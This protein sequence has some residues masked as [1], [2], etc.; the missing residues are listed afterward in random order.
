M[1]VTSY[2]QTVSRKLKL[3]RGWLHFLAQIAFW[4]GFYVVYQLARG[5]ADRDV[6]AAFWNGIHVIR[7]E[8]WSGTLFEP[9]LQ[10]MVDSSSLLITATTLVAVTLLSVRERIRDYGVLKAIGLTPLQITSTVVS[11]HAALARTRSRRYTAS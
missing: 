10:R 5:L 1:C 3:P 2:T 6:S 7:I 4:L 8:D 11:A 9:A